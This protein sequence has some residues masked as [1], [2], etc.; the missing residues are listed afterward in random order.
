MKKKISCIIVLALILCAGG[1]FFYM[2]KNN[3]SIDTSLTVKNNTKVK[4]ETVGL[5]TDNKI[6]LNRT[7]G[8]NFYFPKKIIEQDKTAVIFIVS[9]DGKI[10]KSGEITLKD[11]K[12]INIQEIKNG[13]ISLDVNVKKTGPKFNIPKLDNWKVEIKGN[14][15]E[16]S[17]KADTDLNYTLYLLGKG[18][19]LSVS[20]NGTKGMSVKASWEKAKQKLDS[21]LVFFK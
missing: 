6:V 1:L 4:I 16:G 14:Y 12:K 15:V 11:N 3:D 13:N 2:N 10:L 8:E 17:Y 20:D 7:N 9:K 19:T 21:W 5:C 18:G